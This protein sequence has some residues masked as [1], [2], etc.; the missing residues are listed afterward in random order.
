M[1]SN[2]LLTIVKTPS[3]CPGRS[4]PHKKFALLGALILEILSK[5]DSSGRYRQEQL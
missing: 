5:M 3:K 2:N 1:I 4:K